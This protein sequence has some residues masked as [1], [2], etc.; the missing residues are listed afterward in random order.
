ML[1]SQ[2]ATEGFQPSIEYYLICIADTLMF[3]EALLAAC[4]HVLEALLKLLKQGMKIYFKLDSLQTLSTLLFARFT[5]N[6][7]SPPL[8]YKLNYVMQFKMS[9]ALANLKR[10]GGFVEEF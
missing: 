3:G 2:Q 8:S 7:R 9:P 6:A 4:L 10:F 1:R 5:K